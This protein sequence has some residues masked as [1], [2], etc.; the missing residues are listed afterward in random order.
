MLDEV[1]PFNPHF[2]SDEEPELCVRIRRRGY[3]IVE[4]DYPAVCH[5]TEP[6]EALSTLFARWRR[7][8]Y[9]GPGQILRYH[10]G[11]ASSGPT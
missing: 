11:S 8:L 5:Y 1:G 6:H 3:R 10:L 7:R 4:T 2:Y 9:L